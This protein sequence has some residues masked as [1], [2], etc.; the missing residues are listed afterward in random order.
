MKL[1]GRER[2][3]LGFLGLVAALLALRMA[4]QGVSAG[5]GAGFAAPGA[6]P[7]GARRSAGSSRRN[8]SIPTEILVLRTDRLDPGPTR[9]LEV[10]RDPFRF[11]PLPLPPAPPGPSAEELARRLEEEAERRRLAEQRVAELGPQPP[12]VDVRFLGSFGPRQRRIAVF[13]DATGANVYDAREGDTVDDR[14]VV[15]RIGYES[16]DIGFVGFPDV[17][18]RRL[19]L[20]P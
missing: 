2:R 5:S 9:D 14:F 4:W 19:G 1:S 3:L 15:E 8:G 10:G 7:S 12:E 13:A 16:V 17:P 11:A 6:A 18:A 20:A